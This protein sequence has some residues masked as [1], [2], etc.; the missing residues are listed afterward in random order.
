MSDPNTVTNPEA[1]P[2]R[3]LQSATPMEP[4]ADCPQGDAATLDNVPGVDPSPVSNEPL[5]AAIGSLMGGSLNQSTLLTAAVNSASNMPAIN[6]FNVA[7]GGTLNVHMPSPS[8]NIPTVLKGG[9]YSEKAVAPPARTTSKKPF[10]KRIFRRKDD[11]KDTEVEHPYVQKVLVR[12]N[13][14]AFQLRNMLFDTGADIDIISF[15][16]VQDLGLEDQIN[17]TS[18]VPDFRQWNGDT[19]ELI[20]TINL[21]WS[22]PKDKKQRETLFN[23]ASPRYTDINVIILGAKS[24]HRDE[25]LKAQVFMATSNP[26]R[27]RFHRCPVQV[28]RDPTQQAALAE[29]NRYLDEN[30]RRKEEQKRIAEQRRS[31]GR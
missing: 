1:L 10:Y 8:S 18:G 2:H 17:K 26:T 29:F 7:S 28:E 11:E 25:P 24:I 15:K 14:S 13:D 9:E 23:V 6:F 20:G 16:D 21:A 27:T 30:K 4:A 3:L 5:L 12:N 22:F 31:Q 19:V